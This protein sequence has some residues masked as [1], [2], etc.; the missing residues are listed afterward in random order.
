[1][2]K[3]KWR[4]V[5]SNISYTYY[6]SYVMHYAFCTRPYKNLIIYS[7]FKRKKTHF[8]IWYCDFLDL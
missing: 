7:L 1:M 3:K 6:A 4:A 8:T 5:F 2:S